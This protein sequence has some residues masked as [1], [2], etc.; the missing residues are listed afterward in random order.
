MDV[1]P[2]IPEMLF[3]V[4]DITISVVAGTFEEHLRIGTHETSCLTLRGQ[5]ITLSST[6]DTAPHLVRESIKSANFGT[7][8]WLAMEK[9]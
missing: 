3:S 8:F 7:A 6:Y 9:T 4:R 5:P 1:D 2:K